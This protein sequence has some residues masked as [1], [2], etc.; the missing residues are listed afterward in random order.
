[1]R[2]FARQRSPKQRSGGVVG[3]RMAIN[4]HCAS[5]G[6]YP[7]GGGGGPLGVGQQVVIPKDRFSMPQDEESP[8]RQHLAG[9]GR[10]LGGFCGCVD[11]STGWLVGS[12]ERWVEAAR[13]NPM[14]PFGARDGSMACP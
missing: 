5:S 1:M 2:P 11:V 8:L 3:C 10:H 9:T 13:V 12:G 6:Q 14:W 4:Q 7:E